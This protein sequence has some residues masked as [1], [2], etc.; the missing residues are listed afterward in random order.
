MPASKY[1]IYNKSLKPIYKICA[2]LQVKAL[3]QTLDNKL[4]IKVTL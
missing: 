2:Y 3:L 1:T 4:K